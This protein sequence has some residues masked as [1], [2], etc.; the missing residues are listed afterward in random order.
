MIEKA[1]SPFSDSLSWQFRGRPR[2]A[3]KLVPK[4]LPL[5]VYP[6]S[7]VAPPAADGL[8]YLLAVVTD[9]AQPTELLED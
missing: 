5:A 3:H 1:S 7:A 6:S 8:D 9:G 2:L 4:A